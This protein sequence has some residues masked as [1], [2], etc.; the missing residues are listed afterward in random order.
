[1]TTITQDLTRLVPLVREVLAAHDELF[2][3]GYGR[4][5]SDPPGDVERLRTPESVGVIVEVARWFDHHPPSPGELRNRTSY[6]LK[7]DAEAGLDA[8]VG[9]YVSSGQ[10]I[11]ALLAL[12]YSLVTD[13]YSP[14]LRYPRCQCPERQWGAGL[15]DEALWADCASCQRFA[16]RAG[17]GSF[18]A[19]RRAE[20]E[21][22]SERKRRCQRPG[23]PRRAF[24]ATRVMAS[25]RGAF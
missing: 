15:W 6:G 17:S 4:R 25:G 18:A 12:G 2:Y 10:A 11:A 8:V 9:Y 1:M 21:R 3:G 16:L 24:F 20:A 13:A 5:P 14:Q 23:Q 7:H 22:D 19:A